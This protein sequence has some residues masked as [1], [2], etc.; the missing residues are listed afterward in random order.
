META[1]L[2]QIRQTV[3]PDSPK[4]QSAIDKLLS[5]RKKEVKPQPVVPPS[6]IDK[7]LSERKKEVKPQPVVPP[8]A[9]DK[10]LSERKKDVKPVVPS[11][12]SGF[13]QKGKRIPEKTAIDRLL[14]KRRKV[15]PILQP[16]ES[17]ID[18]LLGR[19]SKP[20]T[21]EEPE[22]LHS[23]EGNAIDEITNILNDNSLSSAQKTARIVRTSVRRGATKENTAAASW[24][25]LGAAKPILYSVGISMAITLAICC[26]WILWFGATWSLLWGVTQYL[27]YHEIPGI[28]MTTIYAMMTG[29]S[30]DTAWSV[31][32]IYAKRDPKW[33][34]ALESKIPDYYLMRVLGRV[35]VT[36]EAMKYEDVIKGVIQNSVSFGVSIYGGG[37]F[38][39]LTTVGIK[40]GMGV[41]TKHG[42]AA[43]R[44]V[45]K[46]TATL[47]D[48]ARSRHRAT[49][50]YLFGDASRETINST[51]PPDRVARRI[52][53]SSERIKRDT[54]NSM[55][56]GPS[57]SSVRDDIIKSVDRETE[58]IRKELSKEAKELGKIVPPEK[59]V[60]VE[61]VPPSADDI[62]SRFAALS[63]PS[64]PKEEIPLAVKV[65]EKEIRRKPKRILIPL[66]QEEE[67]IIVPLPRSATGVPILRSIPINPPPPRTEMSQ[68]FSNVIRDNKVALTVGVSTIAAI[69]IA[70]IVD[71][72]TATEIFR[73]QIGTISPVMAETVVPLALQGYNLAAES[74]IVRTSVINMVIEGTGVG[75]VLDRYTDKLT[76][77]EKKEIKNLA[78]AIKAEKDKSMIRKMSEQMFG[79]LTGGY[80]PPSE[81]KKM[82]Y[83]EL[84]DL[85]LKLQPYDRRKYSE[86]NL[87]RLIAQNQLERIQ[88]LGGIMSGA[89][90]LAVR[91]AAASAIERTVTV[92]SEQIQERL[93][94]IKEAEK[95]L[96]QKIA[97]EAIQNAEVERIAMEA[98]AETERLA[99][100]AI[101]SERLAQA[102]ADADRLA[103]EANEA[104]QARLAEEVERAR[105]EAERIISEAEEAKRIQE[106]SEEKAREFIAKKAKS[107]IEE[108]NIR[109]IAEEKRLREELKRVTK[110]SRQKALDAKKA[111]D[112]LKKARKNAAHQKALDK[113][114][115]RI[116]KRAIEEL[117]KD[118]ERSIN[119]KNIH[120]KELERLI[121]E[122]TKALAK[123]AWAKAQEAK[124][125][126]KDIEDAAK[127]AKK[128]IKKA[129]H[130]KALEKLEDRK[131]A[132]EEASQRAVEEA[133]DRLR[134]QMLSG[135]FRDRD[136]ATELE[137]Q[138]FLDDLAKTVDILIVNP[139]GT[140][141]PIV[142]DDILMPDVLKDASSFM[143]RPIIGELAKEAVK[144]TE[145]LI[146]GYG[147]YSG[148]RQVANIGM[149]VGET[150]KDLYKINDILTQ[151][152]QGENPLEIDTNYVGGYLDEAMRLRAP[153]LAKLVED[154][155]NLDGTDMKDIILRALKDQVMEG[156]DVDRLKYE[157]GK[158]MM[159]ALTTGDVNPSLDFQQSL[160]GMLFDKIMSD[161]SV[162]W[163]DIL[164]KGFVREGGSGMFGQFR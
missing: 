146:P 28:V 5:E 51:I 55:L 34:K 74:T 138:A 104:E 128:I 17:S 137:L 9:I 79:I 10:L 72:T 45:T 57:S 4:S 68:K 38:S 39:Y 99:Q 145:H 29:A 121:R 149:A 105:L 140:T 91:T 116:R 23:Q 56:I 2:P 16:K 134:G 136:F 65:K 61:I 162:E 109:Q 37:L 85:Y 77:G 27:A 36:R 6:A 143:I 47:A 49:K 100:E 148:V 111:L 44:G 88:I 62:L 60:E 52:V 155:V 107:R 123:K 18:K 83:K 102:A 82:K 76:S 122:E 14:Q 131:K 40:T 132:Y 106:E 15:S 115:E 126:A 153:S 97:E 31:F 26:F 135:R 41:T 108:K 119:L 139:D 64:P 75:E 33:K 63:E 124:K 130:E 66:R 19:R 73:D 93:A 156:W 11:L 129:A 35:G 120:Q 161:S 69:T 95:E 8:S 117:R 101:E 118:A 150:A 103:Q 152:D 7:L 12:M 89:A 25:L 84:K 90:H 163:S 24:W 80:R 112:D 151:L 58:N 50:D 96:Q 21:T 160:G 164:K 67:E 46:A 142:P 48:V 159:K 127:E 110:E 20:V 42:T 71:P 114:D 86:E 144:A 78:Q 3:S 87:R 94:A 154:A 141:H 133:A 54:V 158:N 13:P 113:L 70:L 98:A 92:G 125:L 81:L 53:E 32:S 59:K 30:V 147:W 157:I 22:V 1:H 43:V